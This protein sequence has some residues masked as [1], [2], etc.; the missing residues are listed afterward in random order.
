MKTLIAVR[1]KPELIEKID[2]LSVQEDRTRSATIRHIVLA[3][4]RMAD[5]RKRA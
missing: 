4:F 3:Y 5:G 2:A 1:L